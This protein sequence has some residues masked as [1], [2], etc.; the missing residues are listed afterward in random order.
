[1]S[2]PLD[3]RSPVPL[4]H[5][6]AEAIRYRI[7]TGALASG[8]TLPPLREAA[9]QWGVNL[10]TVRHAYSAL[11]AQGLVETRAPFGTVVTGGRAGSPDALDRFVQRVLRAAAR[12]GVSLDALRDRLFRV[13]T[14]PKALRSPPSVSV[15]ECSSTQADDLAR[16]LEQAW[17]IDVHPW[18]LEQAGEPP[19]GLVIGTYFHYNDIRTRWPARFPQV[20][21]VAIRPDPRIPERLRAFARRGRR[22]LVQVCERE[23]SMAA[24]IAADLAGI[25]PAERFE[26]VPVVERA[27]GATLRDRC[28]GPILFAPRVWGQLTEAQ[29]SHPR[30]LE[31]RYIIDPDDLAR[32]GQEYG[33]RARAA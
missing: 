15:V 19:F 2:V 28:P 25:L 3:P 32:L 24:N 7:A 16:Q 31:V 13:G 8:T 20:R 33:W 10:H 27:P 18:T 23:L 9:A 17:Q 14:T 22:T 11:A 26:I 6:L 30:A 5:Q 1:V 21:F 4:Y 29:R 12:E